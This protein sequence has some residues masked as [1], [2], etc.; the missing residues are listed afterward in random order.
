MPVSECSRNKES[1]AA[2]LPG[3]SGKFVLA[4]DGRLSCAAKCFL[5]ET[6]LEW[7]SL[8]RHHLATIPDCFSSAT[9]VSP[10][11]ADPARPFREKFLSN[12]VSQL[13]SVHCGSGSCRKQSFVT[14]HRENTSF[15]LNLVSPHRGDCAD[16][17]FAGFLENPHQLSLRLHL[18]T[19]RQ[20]LQHP[21]RLDD[22]QIITS[23]NN[24]Q[25]AL[26]RS[27]HELVDRQSF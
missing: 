4:T 17:D 21:Q 14:I 25:S 2:I 20:M 9:R 22:L 15:H 7:L 11:L 12:L 8:R 19:S 1:C 18:R 10:S 24:S 6:W 13:C 23:R 3:M 26:T 5:R 27:R 16:R